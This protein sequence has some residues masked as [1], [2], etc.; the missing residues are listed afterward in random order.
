M[1]DKEEFGGMIVLSCQMKKKKKR[2]IQFCKF[3]SKVQKLWQ[4]F[5][6]R[7]KTNNF[8]LPYK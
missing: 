6:H 3:N 1:F 2:K 5:T 4:D 8:H 7:L